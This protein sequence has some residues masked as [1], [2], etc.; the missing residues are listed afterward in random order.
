MKELRRRVSGLDVHRDTV[1]AAVRLHLTDSDIEVK[2]QSFSTTSKGL[3]ELSKFLLDHEVTT[4]AMEATGVYWKPV[5]YSLEGMFKELWLCNAQHVKNVPGRKTDLNDA[6][7]LADVVAHGMVKPSFVPPDE[8]R[9][10]R[11]LTRYRKTQV[12]AR[13]KEIQRLEKVLQD[14]CIK[15]TSVASEVWSKSSREI[16][17]AMIDGERNPEVLAE[18]A[19]GR[20]R[21]KKSELEEALSGFFKDR[22]AFMCREIITHIDQLDESI[23]RLTM[24]ITKAIAPFEGAVE[25]VTSIPGVSRTTAEII[26]AE[27]GADMTAFKTPGQLCAWA[28]VAPA[29]YESAGKRKPKG[30]RKGAPHLK[31][32]MVESAKAAARAKN[33]YHS[34]QYQR[35]SKRRGPNKATMA[36]ANS[37]LNTIWHLLTNGEIYNDK[38]PNYFDQFKNEATELKRLTAKIKQLGYEIEVT[39]LSA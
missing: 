13:V 36:V 34:A 39:K 32:A 14:A 30:V 16:I 31:R 3:V 6:E 26:V 38:G 28:G 29:S 24:E 4:V 35:I 10:L 37:M 17:E 25:L 9:E 7:W 20:L 8:I 1:V 5:Y 19:K 2:K 12:D 33:T 22:H 21:G 18:L 27:T 11:E 23:A 15:I